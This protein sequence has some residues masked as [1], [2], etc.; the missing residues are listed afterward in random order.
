MEYK[1]GFWN[2]VET[3]VLDPEK[4]VEDWKALGMNT[5]MSFDFDPEKHDKKGMLRALDVCEKNGMKMIVCDARTTFRRLKEIGKEKFVQDVTNASRDF[6]S[7]PAFFGFHVGDET[8]KEMFPYAEEAYRIVKEAAPN[9]VPFINFLPFWEGDDFAECLCPDLESYADMLD[10][11]VKN[12]GAAMISYD[13]Y[14]HCAYFERE[15]YVDIYFRNLRLFGTVARNNGIELCNCPCCVG[16]WMLVVPDEDLLRWQINTSV[17]HGVTGLM[18]FFVYERTLDGSFRLPPIDLFWERTE[19]FP[20]LSRQNRIFNSFFAEPMS[21]LTLCDIRHFG[22]RTYGGFPQ[23]EPNE[24]IG[25]IEFAVNPVPMSITKY[26][27]ARGTTVYAV[28]N[29]SQNEPTAVSF[30]CGNGFE[31]YSILHRMAPGQLMLLTKSGEDH[32]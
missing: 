30:T 24:D 12:T 8:D 17:T 27:D 15:K 18:Y 14:A 16:H 6:A 5:P 31:R 4:A 20:R 21:G 22:T 23:F 32:E 9:S 28:V 19:T 26:K 3:G 13:C 10:R 25:K 7:H 11:F 29:L 1:I 2:Y